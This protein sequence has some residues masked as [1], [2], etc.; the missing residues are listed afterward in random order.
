MKKTESVHF[1]VSKETKEKA[2]IIAEKKNQ[3][4]NQWYEAKVNK[5]YKRMNRG[6]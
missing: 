2:K 6:G 5:E 1:R 4:P 3:K